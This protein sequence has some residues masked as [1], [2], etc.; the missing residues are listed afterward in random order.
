M[1]ELDSD[2]ADITQEHHADSVLGEEDG[3]RTFFEENKL[4]SETPVEHEPV[5]ASSQIASSM[6]INPHTLQVACV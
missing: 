5:S 1:S 2:M 3:E 6:G 4:R